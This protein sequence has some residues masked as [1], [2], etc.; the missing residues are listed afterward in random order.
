ME[1]LSV[2]VRANFTF[3]RLLWSILT[4]LVITAPVRACNDAVETL[5][6]IDPDDHELQYSVL[7]R[8]YHNC[9]EM[10]S[11]DLGKLNRNYI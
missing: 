1:L 3:S 2:S 11:P 9:L 8:P 4:T 10:D 5:K 7:V 6:I